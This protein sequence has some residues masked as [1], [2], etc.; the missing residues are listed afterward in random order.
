MALVLKDLMT[1]QAEG[2]SLVI[3]GVGFGN[4]VGDGEFYVFFAN[5]LPSGFQYVS[6]CWIDLRVSKLEIW[7]R[8]WE[9]TPRIFNHID[10]ENAT[11]V[12]IARNDTGDFCIVRYF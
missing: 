8:D 1:Y 10:L 2:G 6:D 11:A 5:D 12:R 9:R 3:N 4:G 7:Q